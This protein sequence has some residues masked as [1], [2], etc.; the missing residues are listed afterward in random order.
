MRLTR[1]ASIR[2]KLTVLPLAC[3]AQRR[4][5][6]CGRTGKAGSF[7]TVASRRSLRDLADVVNHYDSH[8]KLNL[9]EPDKKDL[10]EYLKGI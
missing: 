2:S 9:S 8:F 1:S 7:T 6:D 10:V 4:S 3:T 5:R